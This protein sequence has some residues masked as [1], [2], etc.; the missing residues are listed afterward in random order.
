MVETDIFRRQPLVLH[1]WLIPAFLFTIAV[2]LTLIH[3][4]LRGVERGWT[5]EVP[6]YAVHFFSMFNLNTEGN[7]PSWFSA[8]L[9]AFAS[10]LTILVG[11][12]KRGEGNLSWRWGGLAAVF[13]LLSL[14][15]AS[16]LHE[17]IGEVLALFIQGQGALAWPWVFY[18]FALFL[19]VGLV[20][21]PLLLSLPRSAI[22]GFSLAAAV[23]LAGGL[24]I[25]MYSAAIYDE[26]V[27]FAPGL[28]WPWI[29]AAEEF[30]EMTGVI[31][32]IGTLLQLLR[33]AGEVGVIA[34][35]YPS[36]MR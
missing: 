25:E 22:V 20:M 6:E 30:L 24:G 34:S 19:I 9:W 10:G 4:A 1:L 8:L 11:A 26:A 3:L 12:A 36:S 28:S 27:E 14:D 32:A 16:S 33:R 2:A 17:N 7:V 29:I 5:G 15:E 35:R 13:L 23:F 18:G 31:I 21:L